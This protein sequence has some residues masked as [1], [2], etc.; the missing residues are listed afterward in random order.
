MNEIVAPVGAY[1][2][3][4]RTTDSIKPDNCLVFKDDDTQIN[5]NKP[6][7]MIIRRRI[8]DGRDDY[9]D[10]SRSNRCD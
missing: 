10:L 7:R 4:T 3:E 8:F 5:Q 6:W 9:E 2:S 1:A